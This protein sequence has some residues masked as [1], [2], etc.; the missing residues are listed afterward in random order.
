MKR[1]RKRPP[2]WCS[3][4]MDGWMDMLIVKIFALTVDLQ[5][6]REKKIL[7]VSGIVIKFQFIMLNK[8]FISKFYR[9]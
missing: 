9:I 7:L 8:C 4:Y 3:I 1:K 6:F 5:T 2:K